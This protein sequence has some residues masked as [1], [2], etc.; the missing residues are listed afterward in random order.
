MQHGF[1]NHES[2]LLGFK[3]DLEYS[4]ENS[5]LFERVHITTPGDSGCMI[6]AKCKIIE[7]VE[8]DQAIEKIKNIWLDEIRYEAFEDHNIERIPDGFIFNFVTTAPYL[9]VVGKI[10]CRK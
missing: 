9:G 4:L 8:I 6:L 2:D 10:E 3:V 5:E 1:R 7:G